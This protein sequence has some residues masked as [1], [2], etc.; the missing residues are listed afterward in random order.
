MNHKRKKNSK[1]EVHQWIEWP[2]DPNEQ[3]IFNGDKGKVEENEE[4]EE[5]IDGD[6]EM[7]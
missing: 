6:Q 4:E 5:D 1:K 2:F 3:R 7:G